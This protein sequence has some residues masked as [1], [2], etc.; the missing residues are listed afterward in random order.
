MNILSDTG[1]KQDR[2]LRQLDIV[3]E[4]E[5]WTIYLYTSSSGEYLADETRYH[6]A[7]V[8]DVMFGVP[9]ELIDLAQRHS[10]MELPKYDPKVKVRRSDPETSRQA[11]QDISIRV[12][13]SRFKL[14]MAHY[15][16]RN[17]LT[18]E[19]AATYAGLPLTSEY[20]TRCSEMERAGLIASM[21][22]HR[23]GLSGQLRVV[24][25]ITVLGVLTAEEIAKD[26]QAKHR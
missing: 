22:T 23:T 4:G 15:S 16:D 10:V 26:A 18:D 7:W 5:R 1:W 6:Q 9:Q 13:S 21:P 19:E 8:G 17:G 3:F 12:N 20:A 24:R 14:L 11:A 2:F 25:R